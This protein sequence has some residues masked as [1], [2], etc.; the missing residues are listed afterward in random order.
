MQYSLV[1]VIW[2]NRLGLFPNVNKMFFWHVQM[3]VFLSWPLVTHN[4]VLLMFD[5]LPHFTKIY[6]RLDHVLFGFYWNS[7]KINLSG[8]IICLW[9]KLS[10]SSPSF[11][12]SIG[13][14]FLTAL[15]LIGRITRKEAWDL[16]RYVLSA[17]FHAYWHFL[18]L[19]WAFWI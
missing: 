1:Y 7:M 5:V 4:A 14:C 17:L 3:L 2:R 15:L 16:L 9:F 18:L 19:F 12:Q 13:S 8:Q 11:V 6:M 10:D